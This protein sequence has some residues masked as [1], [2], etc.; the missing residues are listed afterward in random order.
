M[1]AQMFYEQVSKQL[2][3]EE[4]EAKLASSNARSI[5]R[6]SELS[7]DAAAQDGSTLQEQ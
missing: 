1:D 7:G 6:T 5:E 2:H 4:E 3:I